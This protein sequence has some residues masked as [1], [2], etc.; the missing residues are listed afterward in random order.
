MIT[1]NLNTWYELEPKI[2]EL[3]KKYVSSTEGSATKPRILYRGQADSKWELNTTLERYGLSNISVKSYCEITLRCVSQ[4]ESYTD[5]N[6]S[7]PTYDEILENIEKKSNIFRLAIPQSLYSY[8]TFLRH[9]GFP[10]P[11]LDWTESPSIATFFALAEKADADSY[12][13]FIYIEMP[14]MSKSL[15]GDEPRIDVCGPYT[16]T[17]KRHFLQ[18]S[19][20]TISLVANNPS[21][22]ESDFSNHKF[23]S[24]EEIFKISNEQQDLIIKITLPRSER[25][26]V[27][28]H[29]NKYNLNH[30]SLLQS[31]EALMKT[32]AFNEIDQRNL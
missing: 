32:L 15:S 9:H 30:F 28:V 6:F 25:H 4:I 12:S 21:V 2:K 13:I 19:W 23:V 1:E 20:Y 26:G 31:E 24:H 3:A 18:Q 17:H 29:L 7:L 5:R 8:W 10:S 14:K 16:K 27:L 22:P 11:L